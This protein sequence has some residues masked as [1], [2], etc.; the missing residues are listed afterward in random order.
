MLAMVLSLGSLDFRTM[1]SCINIKCFVVGLCCCYCLYAM[2]LSFHSW[3]GFVSLN[4]QRGT[5]L[6][7]VSK[8]CCIAV[9][10]DVA[11]SSLFL[12]NIFVTSANKL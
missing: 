10:D 6:M 9:H 12:H 1:N 5:Q 4:C 11:S 3:K 7:G 8:S 2:G